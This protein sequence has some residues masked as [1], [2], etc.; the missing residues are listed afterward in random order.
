MVS[1]FPHPVY[2]WVTSEGTVPVSP[3]GSPLCSVFRVQWEGLK[4]TV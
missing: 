4:V 1:V 3:S 2:G